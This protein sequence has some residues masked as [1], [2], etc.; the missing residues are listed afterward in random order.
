MSRIIVSLMLSKLPHPLTDAAAIAQ[1]NKGLIFGEAACLAEMLG[2]SLERFADY[3]DIPKATL[4]RRRGGRFTR[5]E[6]DH[7]MRYARLFDRAHTT[8]ESEDGA[9]EWLATPQHGL[10]GEVPLDHARTETGA[11]QV[12]TLITRIE[13]GTAL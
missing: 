8:F 11:R 3:V 5:N 4:F 12:E 6:S 13:Y 1:V 9:R 2:I 7:I 10:N